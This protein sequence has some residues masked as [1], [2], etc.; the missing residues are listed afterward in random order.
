MCSGDLKNVLS[1]IASADEMREIAK[2]ALTLGKDTAFSAGE[3]ADGL[4]Y[5]IAAGK[6]LDEI[7][8]VDLSER[9]LVLGLLM[10]ARTA[11]P[12]PSR[13]VRKA[14]RDLRVRQRWNKKRRRR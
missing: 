8:C 2:L 4:N 10:G 5:L 11:R 9:A 12:I 13:E 6:A 7:G 1:V 3:I 14:D